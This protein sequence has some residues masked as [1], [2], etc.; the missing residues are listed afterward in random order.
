M[1]ALTKSLENPWFVGWVTGWVT[2]CIAGGA[3]A[4]ALATEL[5]S[6]S[7]IRLPAKLR[8]PFK[9]LASDSRST[10]DLPFI[11]TTA[12]CPAWPI[13]NSVEFCWPDCDRASPAIARIAVNISHARHEFFC[14]GCPQ[15]SVFRC[16]F[17][18]PVKAS[19]RQYHGVSGLLNTDNIDRGIS[20]GTRAGRAMARQF[21]GT[22]WMRRHLP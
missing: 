2:G 18:C 13:T 10:K 14:I 5:G 3:V 12:A 11:W 1:P 8:E 6:V 9:S 21:L 19:R 22:D 20:T 4:G 15:Y 7:A 16:P 17:K